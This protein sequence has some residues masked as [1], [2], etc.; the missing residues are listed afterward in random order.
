MESKSKKSGRPS[1]K[2]AP[3]SDTRTPR[4][5]AEVARRAGVSIFM[6][7]RAFCA[8]P[9]VAE[10]TR[11]RVLAVAREIGYAPNAAAKA[12]RTGRVNTV[13]LALPARELR[14]EFFGELVS[15][16]RSVLQSNNLDVLLA[17]APDN[18]PMAAWL[19]ELLA[20][21]Q[22]GAMGL[23]MYISD[24]AQLDVLRAYDIPLLLLNCVPPGKGRPPFSSVGFDHA[25]GVEQAVRHLVTLGHRRIAFISCRAVVWQDVAQ[26]E[27]GFRRGMAE[28]GLS[29]EGRVIM[30]GDNDGPA[31][32]TLGMDQLMSQSGPKV[33]AIV[34]ATDYVALGALGAANR[35]GIAVPRD[36]SVV[37]FDDYFWT[38][39]Y[40]PPLTTVS[41]QGWELGRA[42]ARM[43]IDRLNSPEITP[44]RLILP[45]RLVVRGT[46]A[47]PSKAS[48]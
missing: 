38:A 12:L 31:A 3:A 43:V 45:T 17:S 32:G 6:V 28:A 36:L 40:T 48:S 19:G 1:R 18:V 47:P 20:A 27:E 10:A 7:S 30:P 2:S 14:G 44:K 15:A 35:W 9:V 8:S 29:C 39:F 13:G 25:T 37:G 26:R 46:T 22:C 11:E 23:L 16:F 33:T 42:A 41:H 34:C 21:G 4:S 24:Y 5:A